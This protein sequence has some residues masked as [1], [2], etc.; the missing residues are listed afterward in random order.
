MAAWRPSPMTESR[1][2]SPFSGR[3]FRASIALMPLIEDLLVGAEHRRCFGRHE[4]ALAAGD[5]GQFEVLA[6]IALL[7]DIGEVAE[8]V[9]Q[10]GNVDEL[11][12]ARRRLIEAGGLQLQLGLRL[13][14][15]RGPGIETVDV[16]ARSRSSAK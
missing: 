4:L 1:M 6:E 8:D 5:P 16:T 9:D 3:P 11:G 12:E 15:V 10:F 13:T 2:S 7:N 14:E